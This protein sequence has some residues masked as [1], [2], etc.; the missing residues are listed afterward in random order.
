MN[1]N[2]LLITFD[3]GYHEASSLWTKKAILKKPIV[4]FEPGQNKLNGQLKPT[5]NVDK[6]WCHNGDLSQRGPQQLTEGLIEHGR[7][8]PAMQGAIWG[9]HIP[10]QAPLHNVTLA[11]SWAGTSPKPRKDMV[12]F[13]LVLAS[14][15]SS[16]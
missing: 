1:F 8:V 2:M 5:R 9:R 7:Q 15:K 11:C 16:L 13:I 10:L 3:L 12:L 4:N 14:I 6:R